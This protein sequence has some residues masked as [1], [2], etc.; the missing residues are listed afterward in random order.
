MHSMTRR[1]MLQGL[2]ATAAAIPFLSR[3]GFA[4]SRPRGCCLCSRTS[5][6]T[7]GPL[8]MVVGSPGKI[9][10]ARSSGDAE[11]DRFLGRALVR[12]STTFG[13]GPGFAFFDDGQAPNAFATGQT[14]LSEGHGTVLMGMHL[15]GQRMAK[16][17]DAGMTVI[18]ICAHEFGHIHQIQNGY[19]GALAKLDAT[20]KPLELHA[21]FLAGFYLGNRKHEHPDLDLQTVGRVYDSIGDTDYTSPQHHGTPEER[22]AAI[23]KGFE[24]QRDARNTIDD[25]ARAG[26]VLVERMM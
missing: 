2:G 20:V 23:T 10:I 15:F 4:Q 18:A 19:H 5:A 12:L 13:V 11:T 24:F 7:V 8:G 3:T 9:R 17:R 26:M 14:L 22:I 21:D 1:T 25:A 6:E 16:D